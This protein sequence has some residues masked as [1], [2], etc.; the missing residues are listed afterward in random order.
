MK[1]ADYIAEVTECDFK[2]S[3][4]SE[5]PKSWLKSVSAF[6]NGIGGYLFF[7]VDNDKNPVGLNAAQKTADKISEMIVGRIS[8]LPEFK[9]E[10][11]KEDGAD[12]LILK[13]SAGRTTPYYYVYDNTRIAYIRAGNESVPAPDHI[14][15]ELIL[16]GQNKTFDST[17][18]K[19]KKADYSFTLMEATYRQRANLKFEPKDY[20]SI[21]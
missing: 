11:I 14:L 8:P 4:E 10:G 6:A 3:L 7:G 2:A 5:K 21:A 15:N 19:Y 12:V 13:V 16:K 17:L 20:I 1:L 18:T 9:L